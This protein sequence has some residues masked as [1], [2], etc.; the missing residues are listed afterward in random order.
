V[1]TCC[2]R[3]QRQARFIPTCTLTTAST[4]QGAYAAT[5]RTSLDTAKPTSGASGPLSTRS[6][7]PSTLPTILERR[8]TLMRTTSLEELRSRR[9]F[10]GTGTDFARLDSPRH[11]AGSSDGAQ[12]QSLPASPSAVGRSSSPLTSFPG[13]VLLALRPSKGDKPF[14]AGLV[15]D[16]SQGRLGEEDDDDTSGA[17]GARV[18]DGR[19]RGPLA[20][21][22]TE[23]HTEGAADGCLAAWHTVCGWK[24]PD[25]QWSFD[26]MC[27]HRTTAP[28]ATPAM[29][30]DD[31]SVPMRLSSAVVCGD[32]RW[33]GAASHSH[34][35]PAM[36]RAPH[37]PLA[38]FPPTTDDAQR[39]QSQ[40]ARE[41][42]VSSCTPPPP[43]PTTLWNDMRD[44]MPTFPTLDDDIFMDLGLPISG[45]GGFS[46]V[47][48]RSLDDLDLLSKPQESVTPALLHCE[49]DTATLPTSLGRR[50]VSPPQKS[51]PMKTP[52]SSGC[53]AACSPSVPACAL[54]AEGGWSLATP[55]S[56]ARCD[57]DDID[58]GG[59][60]GRFT[61]PPLLSTDGLQQWRWLRCPQQG[62]A[63]VGGTLR[64]T[65]HADGLRA[66]RHDQR[67]GAMFSSGRSIAAEWLQ[68][69]AVPLLPGTQ[70]HDDAM[71]PE[72]TGWARRHA[73]SRPAAAGRSRS[74]ASR[75]QSRSSFLLSPDVQ[76]LGV[77]SSLASECSEWYLS[78]REGTASAPGV[79]GRSMGLAGPASQ[80]DDKH[81]QL[82]GP[83]RLEPRWE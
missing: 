76:K 45:S 4:V 16:E 71:V 35:H 42:L 62:G 33:G 26:D 38:T 73:G 47:P 39:Q 54:R 63:V 60:S 14:A 29:S 68:V 43:S 74:V 22:S 55:P 2:K 79:S 75:N 10:G 15:A 59:V 69:P 66:L 3:Q 27:L 56:C 52:S 6:L 18:S 46:D 31:I 67:P 49:P 77:A 9:A 5:R 12:P 80:V 40:S 11:S 81:A 34:G 30:L 19:V 32:D 24:G 21:E 25:Q 7:P 17:D 1:W 50:K 48:L 44:A 72:A 64:G 23:G 13:P 83:D 37:C 41:M 78:Q 61:P 51:P 65:A 58:N 8:S 53:K 57:I 20:G 82:T 36:P 28:P 70:C